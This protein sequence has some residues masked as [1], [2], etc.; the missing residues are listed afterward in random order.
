MILMQM[1]LLDTDTTA[2]AETD[3]PGPNLTETEA[4]LTTQGITEQPQ[5]HVPT[6]KKT[7]SERMVNSNL[8]RHELYMSS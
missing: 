5:S 1:S 8:N 7:R 4:E 6:A 2:D 3:P